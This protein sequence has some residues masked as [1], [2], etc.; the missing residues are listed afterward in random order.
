MMV[1]KTSEIFCSGLGRARASVIVPLYNYEQYIIETLDSVLAQT[2]RE[3]DLIVI[4]DCS[5]DRSVERVEQWMRSQRDSDIGLGLWRNVENVRLATTRNT[6]INL[7]T[8][9]YC[10]FLDADNQIYP[11]CLEKH[12]DAL[13]ARPAADAAYSLI[14]VFGKRAGI[15]GAGVFERDALSHGNF[16]DAMAMIRRSTLLALDGFHHID[17][18]WEDYDFWLR[19]CEADGMAV[20]IPEILSRYRE[21]AAS[22][23]RTETNIP[24]HISRLHAEMKRRHP[25]LDLR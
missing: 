13:D 11:R 10:F 20:H 5:T 22:M 6:G 21:H 9:E 12:L 2:C 19:L 1:G 17:H 8:S 14:Q 16:I 24:Q 7:S 25:W 3:I 15:V 23:L 18:G 4:D